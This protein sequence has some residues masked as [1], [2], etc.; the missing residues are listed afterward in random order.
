MASLSALKAV[1]V[2]SWSLTANRLARGRRLDWSDR[3]LTVESP[4]RLV[5]ANMSAPKAAY[6]VPIGTAQGK[7][8]VSTWKRGKRRRVCLQTESSALVWLSI[9]RLHR[10]EE[11]RVG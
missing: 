9:H 2:V 11:R 1:A 3:G 5:M 6:C 8:R 4:Y 10:S 7:W